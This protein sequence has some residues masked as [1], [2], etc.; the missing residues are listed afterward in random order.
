MADD[1]GA[2]LVER[3]REESDDLKSRLLVAAAIQRVAASR[4]L[5]AIVSGGTAVDYYVSGATGRSESYPTKW[6]P[7]GDVD[8]VVVS[9][10][11]GYGDATLLKHALESDLGFGLERL[12]KN[13]D[14]E[15]VIGRELVVP[16]FGYGVEIVATELIGDP[17]HVWTVEVDGHEVLLRG[18]E[19]CLL[20]YAESG[21]D[22]HNTHEW[23]RALAIAAAMREDLDL[24]YLRRAARARNAAG[25]VEH[26]LSGHALGAKRTPLF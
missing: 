10:D 18:P 23:T 5:R 17:L 16:R 1:V 19:D 22:T 8:V 20:Q 2:A 4:G 12:G 7:S 21:W 15:V 24:P 26:A 6:R 14:G 3:A 25:V 9:V 11:R 13:A